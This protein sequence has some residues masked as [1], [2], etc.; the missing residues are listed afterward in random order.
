MALNPDDYMPCGHH[1]SHKRNPAED[2]YVCFMCGNN[3]V[4]PIEPGRA[5]D[6]NRLPAHL[7]GPYLKESAER[8]RLELL[9]ARERRLNEQQQARP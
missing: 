1:V 8:A 5:I 4:I 6:P 7:I 9:H 2:G 3:I